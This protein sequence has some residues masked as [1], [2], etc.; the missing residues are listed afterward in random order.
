[1]EIVELEGRQ[2]VLKDE[3]DRL[4]SQLIE[5]LKSNDLKSWKMT[6]GM[7]VAYVKEPRVRIVDE[8]AL[9]NALKA[10]GLEMIVEERINGLEFRKLSGKLAKEGK[11]LAGTELDEIEYLSVRKPNSGNNDIKN[12]KGE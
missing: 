4:N 3:R 11:T 1:M 8:V 7:T 9:I 10:E 12:P 6:N 2:V 5:T